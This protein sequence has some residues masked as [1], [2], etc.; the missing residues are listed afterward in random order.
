MHRQQFLGRK[1]VRE[2]YRFVLATH[3]TMQEHP[4]PEGA[5][6]ARL[7]FAQGGVTAC[8][9]I[10]VA[11]SAIILRNLDRV[12][13]PPLVVH[14]EA[15][16]RG[17]ER[18]MRY[19]KAK[20]EERRRAKPPDMSSYFTADNAVSD[21]RSSGWFNDRTVRGYVTQRAMNDDDVLHQ[22]L[23]DAR[24]QQALDTMHTDL[25][26]TVAIVVDDE[27]DK[28]E[29][30]LAAATAVV[31]AGG[32]TEAAL[33][34]AAAEVDR[35]R[36]KG[37]VHPRLVDELARA[38]QRAQDDGVPQ[39][40]VL[41]CS[42]YT[43]SIIFRQDGL[44]LYDSHGQRYSGL[45]YFT[46]LDALAAFVLRLCGVT[47]GATIVDNIQQMNDPS[48]RAVDCTFD[49]TRTDLT[50]YEVVVIESK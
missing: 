27:A 41:T 37:E 39:A 15:F 16:R 48:L 11:I 1:Q 13:V 12:L 25:A 31:A 14:Q 28:L 45:Y 2:R 42:N 20:L 33:R 8:A 32:G 9:H 24:I 6:V 19:Y 38:Y 17:T 35:T 10:S 43:R 26:T 40:M 34:A 36:E 23:V 44:W 7:P 5:L 21:C 47:D 22:Q 3:P 18:G 4:T 49:P 46:T 50:A 29:S 30:A